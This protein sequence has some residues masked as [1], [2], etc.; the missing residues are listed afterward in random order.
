M[1]L[2]NRISPMPESYFNSQTQLF[3]YH[4][5]NF[6]QDY[7]ICSIK[8][9]IDFNVYGF[10]YI[11]PHKLVALWQYSIITLMVT[12]EID[13]QTGE[14]IQNVTITANGVRITQ[15]YKLFSK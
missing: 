4:A 3:T 2:F 9:K 13:E 14:Q 10:G 7:T 6:K 5:Y 11:Q 15:G 8:K 1:Q 12:I